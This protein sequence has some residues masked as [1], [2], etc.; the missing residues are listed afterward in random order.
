MNVPNVVQNILGG[1]VSSYLNKGSS[2]PLLKFLMQ[3]FLIQSFTNPSK[4]LASFSL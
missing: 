3:V 4:A 1:I 2:L